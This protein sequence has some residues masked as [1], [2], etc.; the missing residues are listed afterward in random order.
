MVTKRTKAASWGA[1]AAFETTQNNKNGKSF[2]ASSQSGTSKI[3]FPAPY[4][5][6]KKIFPH[7]INSH[8]W[9]NVRCCFHHDRNPSL[10]I[11][12]KSGG[13]I[14]HACGAKGADILSFH[15]RKNKASFKASLKALHEIKGGMK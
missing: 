5:Y 14:C 13:F 1:K 12:L 8:E 7:I 2:G 9:V 4:A 11:N 3:C 6:Y 15:M 10:S